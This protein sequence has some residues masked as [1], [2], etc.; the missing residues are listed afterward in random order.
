VRDHGPGVAD[1]EKQRIF[2]RFQR[3]AA[4]VNTRGSGVGLSVVQLL[5]GAMGGQ[6]AVAD[7]PGGGA[8]FQLQLPPA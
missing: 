1:L 7:A 4:A 5:M 8:D 6:V 2:E 3:G